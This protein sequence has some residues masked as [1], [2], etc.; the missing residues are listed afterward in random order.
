MCAFPRWW[1]EWEAALDLPMHWRAIP[2]SRHT[3]KILGRTAKCDDPDSR[4][5]T[6]RATCPSKRNAN[7]PLAPGSW[8]GAYVRSSSHELRGNP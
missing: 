7:V 4:A 1:G 8:E 6:S 3:V 5:I 2:R